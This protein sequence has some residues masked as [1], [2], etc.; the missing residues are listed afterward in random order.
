LQKSN[1]IQLLLLNSKNGWTTED[2]MMSWIENVLIPYIGKNNSLLLMDSYEAHL[3]PK[4]Q[5]A[6]AKHKNLKVGIIV[7]GTTSQ[8]Q[9]LDVR[10]NKSFKD[11]CKKNLLTLVMYC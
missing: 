8:T 11:S 4:V 3:T 9:P 6:L 7:G 2:T 5:E 1:K 10:V